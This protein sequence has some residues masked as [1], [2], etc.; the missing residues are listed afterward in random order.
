MAKLRVARPV[1]DLARSEAQYAALGLA[2]LYRFADH[3]DGFDGLMLGVPGEQY[4]LELTRS[5]RSAVA[6]T[7]TVE[8]LL[9]FYDPD[10]SDWDAR[11]AALAAAG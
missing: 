3:D 1:T 11:C 10:R 2:V 7:P 5:A 6:P 8:D 9:V 4:H